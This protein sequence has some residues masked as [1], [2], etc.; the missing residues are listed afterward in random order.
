VKNPL[1]I[2]IYPAILFLLPACVNLKIDV[3]DDPGW[4]VGYFVVSNHLDA[5]NDFENPVPAKT[6][7][8]DDPQVYA[9]IKILKIE[10][11]VRIS[12]AWYGPDRILAKRSADTEVN[13]GSRFLEYFVIWDSLGKSFYENKKGNWTVAVTADGKFLMK[14]DFVIN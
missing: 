12:W 9:I 8:T 13:T 6:L 11:S 5:D 4:G 14:K 2:L 3:P 1:V 7:R 10:K